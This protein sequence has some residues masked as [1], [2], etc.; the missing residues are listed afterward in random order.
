MDDDALYALLGPLLQRR[1]QLRASL[2]QAQTAALAPTPTPIPSPTTLSPTTTTPPPVPSTASPT[3]TLSVSSTVPS[4][5]DHSHPSSTTPI[6][7]TI[8]STSW[9]SA[10]STRTYPY[11][12]VVTPQSTQ[13]LWWLFLLLP[14]GLAILFFCR[15]RKIHPV[16][17]QNPRDLMSL[18]GEENVVDADGFEEIPL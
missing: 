17:N 3:S 5:T 14:I 13:N 9:T 18:T 10:S 4:T 2:L 15:W 11:T 6:I 1:P 7:W 16:E 12:T 8:S